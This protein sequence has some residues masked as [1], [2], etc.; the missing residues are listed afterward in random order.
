MRL[1]PLLILAALYPALF[2]T[3]ASAAERAPNLIVILA[4]DLGWADL[5]HDGSQID[6]PNLDRLAKEGVTHVVNA[7]AEWGGHPALYAELGV[8]FLHVP[9]LDFDPPSWKDALR[10]ADF[11]RDALQGGGRVC[12]RPPAAAT[13]ATQRTGSPSR[14]TC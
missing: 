1:R 9:T 6:T 2:L 3:L 12:E 7:C 5:G 4:D 8:R 10:S 11:V 13:G 14:S